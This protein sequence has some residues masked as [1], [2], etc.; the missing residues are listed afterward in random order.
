M[1]ADDDRQILKANLE[2]EKATDRPV[3][4]LLEK[5]EERIRFVFL[6]KDA[7]QALE[8]FKRVT[9]RKN[10]KTSDKAPLQASKGRSRVSPK[11][12]RTTKK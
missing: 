1:L 5:D 8:A 12:K 3:A 6:A 11:S 2:N 4:Y 9:S 10:G 7:P